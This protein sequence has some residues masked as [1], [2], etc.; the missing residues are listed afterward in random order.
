M[1]SHDR[2]S[3]TILSSSSFFFDG[4]TTRAKVYFTSSK[5]SFRCCVNMSPFL[6]K[7]CNMGIV[8]NSSYHS[9]ISFVLCL[10]SYNI[11]YSFQ[12]ITSYN[13]ASFTMLTWSYHRWIGYSFAVLFML[14]WMHYRPRYI[15]RY[16]CSYPVGEWSSCT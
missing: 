2:S 5:C 8:I 6:C 13:Y 14:E 7:S 9:F 3:G 15:S 1:F 12:Y 11:W 4:P 10:F 16:C